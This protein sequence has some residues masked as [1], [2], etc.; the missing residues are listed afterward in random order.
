MDSQY[1]ID[2]LSFNKIR[3]NKY[4]LVFQI[5]N[6]LLDYNVNII[7]ND[8][9]FVVEMPNK[10]GLSL[11]EKHPVKTEDVEKSVQELRM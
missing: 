5:E 3:G 10:L 2:I 9:V 4:H 11:A 6:I 8:G 1:E 7:D